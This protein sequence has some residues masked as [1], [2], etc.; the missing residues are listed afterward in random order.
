M[1]KNELN[2]D[3]INKLSPI[4]QQLKIAGN[5]LVMHRSQDLAGKSSADIGKNQTEVELKWKI[6][7][8]YKKIKKTFLNNLN[9][10]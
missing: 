10:H 1:E 2:D 4:S 7:S 3:E 5:K 6:K 9:A 8:L